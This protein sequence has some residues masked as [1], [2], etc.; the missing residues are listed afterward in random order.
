MPRCS[1]ITRTSASRC[2]EKQF[3]HFGESSATK[4]DKF[5]EITIGTPV[6]V[7]VEKKKK[8]GASLFKYN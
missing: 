3:G 8:A 1:Q 4:L 7:L 5:G 6:L 2:C